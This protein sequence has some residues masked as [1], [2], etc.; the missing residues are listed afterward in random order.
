MKPH[1]IPLSSNSCC[2]A[3]AAAIPVP[4]EVDASPPNGQPDPATQLEPAA[5]GN[6]WHGKRTAPLADERLEAD[7]DTRVADEKDAEESRL[8][9]TRADDLRLGA[10]M[11]ADLDDFEDADAED[12]VESNVAPDLYAS[13]GP[14]ATVRAQSANAFARTL[15]QA[16]GRTTR[17]RIIAKTHSPTA[18]NAS[19]SAAGAAPATPAV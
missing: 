13:V 1:Q 9:D 2:A 8:V 4:G 3:A 7:D 14:A 6:R 18:T 11:D 15:D 5:G 12:E 17:P 19:S 16:R 10:Q